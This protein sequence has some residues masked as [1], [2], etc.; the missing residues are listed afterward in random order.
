MQYGL[1]FRR[2][3]FCFLM[4]LMLEMCW[5]MCLIFGVCIFDVLTSCSANGKLVK[6]ASSK[7]KWEHNFD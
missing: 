1:G 5:F 7:L 6:S 4:S 3:Q 2:L